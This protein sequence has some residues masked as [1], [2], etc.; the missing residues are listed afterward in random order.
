MK[1]RDFLKGSL[2]VVGLSTVAGKA[3]GLF[4]KAHA[5]LFVKPGTLGFKDVAPE[6]Q[7]KAGKQCSTCSW[8]KDDKKEKDAGLCTLKAMQNAMKSEAV[9][10][11]VGSYC[12]MWKK[13]A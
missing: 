9:Y 6:A 8:F 2:L 10:V 11:K 1:R 5:A 7:V 4:N 3:A 13:K 12:N